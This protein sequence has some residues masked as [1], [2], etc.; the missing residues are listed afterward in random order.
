MSRVNEAKP[1]IKLQIIA[2]EIN[3]NDKDKP[4]WDILDNSFSK[5]KNL[6]DYQ[7]D[8]LNYAV[9]VLYK[10]FKEL[11]GNKE[12]FAEYYKDLDIKDSLNIPV[13]K[14]DK[15]EELLKE[16][17]TIKEEKEKNKQ[18]IPF[19]EIC[20]RMSFWMATGSGKTIVIIKLIEI[21][22]KLMKG[23]LIPK[24]DILFLTYR[25]DLIESFKKFVEEYN[26]EKGPNNQINLINLKDYETSKKQDS[27]EEQKSAKVFY[28]RSDLI[29]DERKENILNFRD[30]LKMINGKPT[31][32][33]YLILD[34]AHKGDKGESKRQHLFSILSKNGFLFNFSATFTHP[35]DIVSTVFN[36]NLDEF[37]D[38]GYGKQIYVMSEN[39]TAFKGQNDFNQEEK[40]KTILKTLI[41]LVLAK[42]SFE[43]IKKIKKIDSDLYHNPIAIY[44][45]NSVNT[46]DADLKLVF[47]E[48]SKI[49]KKIEKNIEEEVKEE[50][51]RLINT[52]KEELK[53]E[54]NNAKYIIGD[55]ADT[56]GF[57]SSLIDSIN[58]EDIC[59]YIFNSNDG[60][61]IE[62]IVNPNNKQEIALKLNSTGKPFALIKIGDI[63]KWINKNLKNYQ[64]V[65]AFEDK[66]Y[67]EKLNDK[68]SPINI[69]LG[70]RAFYEGWDSN[71]PNV[72]TFINI[73]TG[74]DAKKFVLQAIGRGVRIEPM[75]N[76]RKRIS[77]LSVQNQAL[78]NI[79]NK[80]EAKILETLF[81][82]ATNKNA[83]ETIIT[84]LKMVKE[85]EGFS[86]V[87]LDKNPKTEEYTLLIPVYKIIDKS[88]IDLP[89]RNI[90]KFR[91][92]KDNLELLKLYFQLMPD[93]KFLVEYGVDIKTYTNLKNVM[94]NNEKYIYTTEDIK[95]KNISLLINSLIK[96]TKG[97]TE[98]FSKFCSVDDKIV[99]FR[100]IK[101]R[102]DKK[103]N[104]EQLINKVKEAPIIDANTLYY[105]VINKEIDSN[106]FEKLLKQKND[107]LQDFDGVK[108]QKL[109]QHFYIPI[110]YA[111]EEDK[112]ID[113]IKHIIKVESEY[114]FIKT[115]IDEKLDKL[116]NSFNEQNKWWMF[117]KLDEHLDKEVYIPY[118][119]NGELTKFIPDFIF[120]FKFDDK[121]II[122]FID[123]K[124][125]K[126]TDYQL[127][128][129]GY[130]RI[131]EI[132]DSPKVFDYNDMKIEVRLKLYKED[133]LENIA[134]GYKKYWVDKTTLFNDILQ[135][136]A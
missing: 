125:P 108:I 122:Y 95:Y 69:L 81:V 73:G 58:K 101:I 63:S 93:E 110:I 105:K 123:P 2:E 70:S 6:F 116:N 113:W 67:F 112:K 64:E 65:N 17:F 85:L 56:L 121:Y 38:K 14:G 84:E 24:K 120:W 117:S 136:K 13:Q 118:Y 43:N 39:I 4:N 79:A 21:L 74:E 1:Y 100:K 106:E 134:E 20:N 96:Y 119:V 5:S 51:E 91:M 129:D 42:K 15:N 62:Y 54:L 68:D 90:P 40:E 36:F 133:G 37:I 49:A 44:L 7:F 50:V 124:G 28:Y 12:K 135:L 10:Y 131:F 78:Q 8:A 76:Q 89:E 46:D 128:V 99:H 35:I 52:V 72:I 75:P 127:K 92:S 22:N 57:T 114:K 87:S 61:N 80:K 83:V 27:E 25:E 102:N 29:S 41:S 34:E 88:I 77:R 132:N 59:N 3:I 130:K 33:W 48:L 11:E 31:G 45:V 18:Y 97:K 98:E 55:K 109:L 19:S 126:Y 30:Y 86:D 111:N 82:Y 94:S 66:K 16:F 26:I 9:R 115:L 32:N 53:K 103:E 107:T 104:F 60:G 23:N 47:E 71:R